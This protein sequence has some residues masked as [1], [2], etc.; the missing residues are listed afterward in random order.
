MSRNTLRMSHINEDVAH[1]MHLLQLS[2]SALPVGM[3]SFSAGLESAVAEGLVFDQTTLRSFVY[4]AV[5]R[6]LHSD[7]IIALA[8]HRASRSG[9]Y[10]LLRHINELSELT[11]LSDERRL[12]SRRMG[13]KLLQLATEIRQHRATVAWANA[14]NRGEI[15]PTL[16]VTQGVIFAAV[17]IGEQ[18]MTSSLL[19]S[20]A[21]MILGAALR[22][23]RI[24]HIET[25]R[26]LY[27]ICSE[28]GELF[29]RIADSDIDD[30]CSFAPQTELCTSLHERGTNRMFMS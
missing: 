13:R 21:S 23:M 27:A 25:Q 10:A 30:V 29:D 11:L 22:L 16:A 26:I 20:A 5:E 19:Y 6:A 17:G 24:S 2:D 15:T 18:E 4:D 9:N 8:A 12:M 7:C 28:S 1:L 14:A 3:F